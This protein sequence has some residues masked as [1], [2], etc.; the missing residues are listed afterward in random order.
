MSINTY[1]ELRI[2]DTAYRLA[3]E[4]YAVTAHFP[5]HEKFGLIS[6]MRRAAVSVPSNIAEGFSRLPKEQVR[7]L[8]IAK[9]SIFELTCQCMMAADLS[10]CER[11][12]MAYVIDRYDGL[13]AGIHRSIEKILMRT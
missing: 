13:A 11:N 12:T 3:L 5:S 1:K 10:Y 2:W 9:G 8:T 4:I 6:Q 7:F